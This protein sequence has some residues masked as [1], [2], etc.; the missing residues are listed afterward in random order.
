MNQ[1]EIIFDKSECPNL[2]RH[3]INQ[4]HLIS[5]IFQNF[6]MWCF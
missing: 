6:R 4:Q 1:N 5:A 2:Q 3:L